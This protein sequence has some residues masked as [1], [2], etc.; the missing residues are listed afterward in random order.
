MGAA[1]VGRGYINY[2]TCARTPYNV[3]CD[4]DPIAYF[5]QTSDNGRAKP[6][7]WHAVGD[8]DRAY[9]DSDCCNL[10]AG[11]DL[12]IGANRFAHACVNSREN[13][14]SSCRIR[15]RACAHRAATQ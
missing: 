10:Y 7:T 2:Q 14:C 3:Y 11:A 13:S 12:H 6:V 8:E 5:H 9:G 15:D 1:V 4:T